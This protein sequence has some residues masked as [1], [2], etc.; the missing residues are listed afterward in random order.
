MKAQTNA[1]K[2]AL[3]DAKLRQKLG[4]A[5]VLCAVAF[6]FTILNL[7]KANAAPL[8]APY[9]ANIRLDGNF[10][11]WRGVPFVCVTPQT[12]VFDAE[13]SSTSDPNDLSFRF[14]V[15]HDDDAL[16]VA[17]EV[18][19]NAVW[20]DSTAPNNIEAPAWD[21]DAVEVF[22]DGNHNKAPDARAEDG[23]ELKFG[24]EFSIVANGAA[25]SNYS[26]FPRTFGKPD[27]WQGATNWK[28]LRQGKPGLI[29]Y[30]F[31]LT[32]KV[33]GGQV[34]PGDTI[35]FT[36]AAQDDDDGKGREHS[37]YWKANS[38]HG[39]RNESAWG[40]I[41]LQPNLRPKARN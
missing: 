13:A 26:G 6:V 37:F 25:M 5:P 39:W 33:M 29:R 12:G 24:G 15:C 19:D 2:L 8:L 34:R 17:V 22:I 4:L 11:D 23:S 16:Y 40:E 31:R 1:A 30:E 35:G 10:K 36:L 32:W 38:P 7:A 14:A 41:F 28:K 18:R 27:F 20:A 21:D 3:A 9:R